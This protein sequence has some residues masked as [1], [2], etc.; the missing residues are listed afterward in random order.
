MSITGH[1]HREQEYGYLSYLRHVVL[2]LYE[3]DRLV[4]TVTEWLSTRG[5]TTPLIFSSLALDVNSSSPRPSFPPYLCVAPR[6]GRWAHMARVAAPAGL[7]MCLQWDLARVLRA[8]PCEASSLGICTSSV[9]TILVSHFLLHVLIHT[10]LTPF[11]VQDYLAT[12]FESLI[13]HL[14]QLSLLIIIHGLSL[15]ARLATHSSSSGHTPPTL[16][17][18]FG[19]LLFGLGPAALSFQHPYLECLRATY[20]MEHLLLAFVRWQDPPSNGS[21]G[22]FGSGP[23]NAASLGIP[24]RLK[25]WIRDCPSMLLESSHS[26]KEARQAPT[27]PW[28]PHGARCQ[29]K[30]ERPHV[31]ARSC[32]DCCK[33]GHSTSQQGGPRPKCIRTI[34]RLGASGSTD[35]QADARIRRQFQERMDLSLNL[36]PHTGVASSIAS[37]AS[38]TTVSTLGDSPTVYFGLGKPAVAGEERFRSLTELKL[39]EF[40]AMG[41]G[42]LD[43]AEKKLQFDLTESTRTVRLDIGSVVL[44]MFT[45]RV[46]VTSPETNDAHLGGFLVHWIPLTDAPRH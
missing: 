25:G 46:A 36:H 8:M 2:G 21:S 1:R 19:P 10:I 39:G 44:L 7:A 18:L 27:S 43:L 37:L 11:L 42:G 33:L 41:F 26:I 29:H 24:T 14:Q 12:H 38:S 34:S 15:L 35:A 28:S 6:A 23:G 40:E 22:S 20:A 5:L 45:Y 4:Y 30:A 31:C 13:A 9:R 17:P 3:V 16:S 32:E